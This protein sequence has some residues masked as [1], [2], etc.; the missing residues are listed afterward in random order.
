MTEQLIIILFIA[1]GILIIPSPYCLLPRILLL[2]SP[3][4]FK[5]LWYGNSGLTSTISAIGN[6]NVYGSPNFV[7]STA[8]NFAT[9]DRTNINNIDFVD[10][11]VVTG[12]LKDAF[13]SYSSACTVYENSYTNLLG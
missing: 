9:T 10:I 8:G 6:N 13:A 5:N 3:T 7:D 11:S 1:V 4:V 2:L 12:M